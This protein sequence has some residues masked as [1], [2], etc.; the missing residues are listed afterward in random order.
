MTNKAFG[1][2]CGDG[3]KVD[4][5]NH[6]IMLRMSAVAIVKVLMPKVAPALKLAAYNIENLH[7]V[8][9]RA[10]WRY[11]LGGRDEGNGGRQ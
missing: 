3:S 7:K 10:C 1:K 6:L 4:N 11:D 8:A 9:W 2:W 5:H